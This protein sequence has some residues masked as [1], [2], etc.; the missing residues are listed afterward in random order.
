MRHSCMLL[1]EKPDIKERNT[2]SIMISTIS[3]HLNENISLEDI[4]RS[5]R[6]GKCDP[7]YN[8]WNSIY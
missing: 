7:R 8:G 1:H 4:D 3:K 6:I 5:H 2:D